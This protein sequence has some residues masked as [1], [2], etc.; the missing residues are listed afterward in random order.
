MLRR[1]L[2]AIRTSPAEQSCCPGGVD[3][4]QRSL[5]NVL[6]TTTHEKTSVV[7]FQGAM[8]LAHIHTGFGLPSPTR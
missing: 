1:T 7:H 5:D 3:E 8:T 4:T 6:P 2:R